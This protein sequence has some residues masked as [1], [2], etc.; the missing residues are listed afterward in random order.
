MKG[1]SVTNDYII[2]YISPLIYPP[3]RKVEDKY[4]GIIKMADDGVK[5]KL[6]QD[7]LETVNDTH[8]TATTRI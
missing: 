3:S 2:Y 7:Q 1:S 8:T 6:D 4:V 5:L